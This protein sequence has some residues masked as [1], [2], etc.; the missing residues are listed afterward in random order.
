M[1]NTNLDDNKK[2]NHI[3]QNGHPHKSTNNRT[4]SIGQEIKFQK[5]S[6]RVLTYPHLGLHPEK[7]IIQRDTCIPTFTAAL[8]PVA[9]T[10]NQQDVTHRLKFKKDVVHAHNA[11]LLTPEKLPLKLK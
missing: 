5:C 2:S 6:A 11:L 4:A 10:Q 3:C 7:T 9:K 8:L 1:K